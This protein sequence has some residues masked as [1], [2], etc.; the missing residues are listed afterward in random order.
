MNK[1][2]FKT[3]YDKTLPSQRLVENTKGLMAKTATPKVTSFK[4]FYAI[5]LPL[6][7]CVLTL[8]FSLPRNIT[9]Q[10][11]NAQDFYISTSL[12]STDIGQ[13]AEQVRISTYRGDYTNHLFEQD[14]IDYAFSQSGQQCALFSFKGYIKEASLYLADNLDNYHLLGYIVYSVELTK[15]YAK[16]GIEKIIPIG[17]TITLVDYVY[18]KADADNILP[19]SV[20]ADIMAFSGTKLTP[21]DI[22]SIE[23]GLSNAF[24]SYKL[25]KTSK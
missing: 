17:S 12:T 6:I 23:I 9:P 1:N 20:Y 13:Q 14:F 3:A 22:S 24:V 11:E 5:A 18:S 7:I 2:D 19:A 25:T 4:L 16:D 21:T 10:I 15:I 8:N